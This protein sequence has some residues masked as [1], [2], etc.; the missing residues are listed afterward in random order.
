M[1]KI[2]A[3]SQCSAENA[4]LRHCRTN[5][6]NDAVKTV[7][8]GHL[9]HIDLWPVAGLLSPKAVCKIPM[10]KLTLFFTGIPVVVTAVLIGVLDF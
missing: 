6:E 2:L 3:L 9:A 1:Y 7:P 5:F 10:P 4:F 8:G